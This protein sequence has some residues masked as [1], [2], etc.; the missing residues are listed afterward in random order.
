MQC[1]TVTYQSSDQRVRFTESISPF[2]DAD[3]SSSSRSRSGSEDAS[4]GS[5]V[6]VMRACSLTEWTLLP[7]VL[8]SV[9]LTNANESAS[10]KRYDR[11]SHTCIV[12]RGSTYYLYN[13][14]LTEA[15][16]VLLSTTA[17]IVPLDEFADRMSI[18]LTLLLT[19]I[20]FK[21]VVAEKLPNLS[22]QTHLDKFIL[23]GFVLQVMFIFASALAALLSKRASSFL[24][25]EGID[26]NIVDDWLNAVPAGLVGIYFVY[27]ALLL[28]RVR[29]S[30]RKLDRLCH[31]AYDALHQLAVSNCGCESAKISE[32][33]DAV[34]TLRDAVVKMA[35]ESHTPAPKDAWGAQVTRPVS[36]LWDAPR[37]GRP[38]EA[39]RPSAPEA[40]I[41]KM[42]WMIDQPPESTTNQK[43]SDRERKRQPSLKPWLKPWRRFHLEVNL[44]PACETASVPE[45][46]D[47]VVHTDPKR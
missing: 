32:M 4:D 23:W 18:S 19:S 31:A 29:W 2:Q 25:R 10:L 15:L 39:R 46:G 35:D 21:F 45:Q 43:V 13:I 12:R 5:D 8:T 11:V 26:V 16:L 9:E 30:R 6:L 34:A 7:Y 17:K 27:F 3:Y 33:H 38:S 37:T 42:G 14:A 47:A 40:G 28:G 44:N 20:A 1:L 22:Y 36:A 41:V 24:E